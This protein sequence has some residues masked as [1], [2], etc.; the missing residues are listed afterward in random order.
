MKK[1]LIKS[2]L[3]I[4]IFIMFTHAAYAQHYVRVQPGRPPMA[5][6]PAARPGYI[7]VGEEW[8]W[9]NGRYIWAGGQ[10]MRAPYRGAIWIP[11]QWRRTHSGLYWVPGHWRRR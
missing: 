8:R 11:G 1:N 4:G 6:P 5:R 10:W 7:W 2:I 9:V 3:S